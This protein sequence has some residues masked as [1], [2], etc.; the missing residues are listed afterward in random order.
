MLSFFLAFPPISDPYRTTGKII[1][2]Y[3]L[4]FM[5]L[6]SRQ[7]EKRFR[8]EWWQ[9]LPEFK[10]L[11]I[12]S[13]IK[14]WFVTVVPKYLNCVTFTNDLLAIF[15]SWLCPEFWWRGT[16]IYFVF[17]VFT[18]RP[19]SLLASIKVDVFFFMVSM[20]SSFVVYSLRI[21]MDSSGQSQAQ[22]LLNSW[23][24]ES[25]VAVGSL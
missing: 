14:F 13:W 9:A 8:S 25:T 12:S 4:I 2:L 22:F 19:T 21:Q 18:S 3:I 16:N 6:D 24:Q 7:E 15:M 11:L 5:F 1:V 20:L 10:F 23:R 17:S